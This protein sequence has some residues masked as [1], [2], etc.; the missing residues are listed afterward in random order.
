M[1]Y[2]KVCKYKEIVDSVQEVKACQC[3]EFSVPALVQQDEFSGYCV[4]ILPSHED[5]LSKCE[6]VLDSEEETVI[7]SSSMNLL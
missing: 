4:P 5:C 3:G 2:Q 6:A 7:Y 1:N